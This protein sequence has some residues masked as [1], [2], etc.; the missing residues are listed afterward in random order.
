MSRLRPYSKTLTLILVLWTLILPVLEASV[1]CR[2]SSRFLARGERAVLEVV[3]LG[4]R[5]ITFPQVTPVEGVK[6]QPSGRGPRTR[7]IPGRRLEHTYSF[8][9]SSYEVGNHQI[10]PVEVLLDSG[11]STTEPLTFSVFN[12]D[13]L[14]WS[15]AMAGRTKFR[16]ASAFKA[17]E[18]QPYIDQAIEVEIKLYIPRDLFVIDWGIP[19]FERDG[20]TAWRMQPRETRS[21]INLLGMPY[22]SVAYPSTMTPNRPGNV[23]IGPAKIRL[24]STKVVMDGILRREQIE[25]WV[26]TPL[27]KLQARQLPPN[28]P[29][30]FENAVGQ[31]KITTSTGQTK[32]KEGD[33]IPVDILIS[34]SGNLDTMN[35]PRPLSPLGWKVYDPSRRQRGDERRELIG[36]VSFQQFLRPLE[37]KSNIPAYKLVFFNP[38]TETYD[39]IQTEAIALQMTPAIGSSSPVG[40]PP[41]LTTPIEEM[42]DILGLIPVSEITRQRRLVFTQHWLHTIGGIAAL[43]LIFRALWLFWRDRTSTD[44]RHRHAMKEL[45]ELESQ[46]HSGHEFLMGA[47][48]FIE[49]WLD[50]HSNKEIRRILEERDA[51]CFRPQKDAKAKI[52]AQHRKHILHTLRRAAS[53]FIIILFFVFYSLGSLHAG[54]VGQMAKDAYQSARYDDSIKLWLG[55]APYSELSAD[56][57]YHIGNACYRAES[58][59]HAA[60]YYRRA[61]TRD[62]LHHEARQNL[63][64]LERKYGSLT[65]QRPDHQYLLALLPLGFW[66]SATWTGLWLMLLA[67]LCYPASR[68]G[69]RLRRVALAVIIFS[70]LV[71]VS[72]GLGWRYYPGDAAFAPIEKQAV[73]VNPEARLHTEAGRNSSVVIET[74]PGSLC[75]VLHQAGEWSYV[76]L[77]TQTRGWLPSAHIE[78]VEPREVP[79]PPKITKPI[80]KETSA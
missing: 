55:A 38:E 66:Q 32:V 46:S 50:H 23:T 29:S 61:I 20:L 14:N 64:F 47:G 31:F 9:V 6:I 63:R 45:K 76:S 60:L 8:I 1:S 39:S 35:P 37:L 30:G 68:R 3:V 67:L 48:R 7:M 26:N 16:Y 54:D 72:S 57:L 15:T 65:I 11:T 18:D 4:K 17:L 24:I 79:K 22:I 13:S 41:K 73:I 74:P 28:A 10:A 69:A 40:P 59:G 71:T 42:T 2:M 19:D 51:T 27:L 75:E 43:T 21:E 12:P 52:E 36:S 5:P 77:A 33:P 49:R 80:A 56:T 78:F 62:G 44:P 53:R 70:P 34:G 25:S 58:P